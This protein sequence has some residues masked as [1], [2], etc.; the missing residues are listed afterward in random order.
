MRRLLVVL[1]GAPEPPGPRPSTLETARTPALDALCREGTVARLRPTPPGLPPGSETG[2]PTLLG[3][4]PSAPIGRGPIEA[5][6]AG[7]DVPAGLGAWRMDLRNADGSRASADAVSVRRPLLGLR[8]PGLR[9]AGIRGHRVVVI[10]RRRPSLRRVGGLDVHV[11]PD[12]AHLEQVLD[13]RTTVVCGPGAAAGIARLL[14]ATAIVPAGATGDVDSD[15]PA[16]A[17]AAVQ[18]LREGGDVVVHVGALDEAAHRRDAAAKRAALERADA[19]VVAP[20]VAAAREMEAIVAVT[21]DHGTCPRT[22]RH[23]P[24]PVPL[25]VA[26]PAIPVR[27]PS[28][29]TE[30][31]VALAPIAREPWSALPALE[32]VG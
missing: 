8:T 10:G 24:G 4:P 27:G 32:A 23:D 31:A 6:A 2:L 25:V 18:A 28:R 22:G 29:L 13:E 11:W 7:V 20:L 12:G 30:R 16:K 26:G 3:A 1:D 9:V 5:A 17:G 21:S 19:E 14:G 15:L